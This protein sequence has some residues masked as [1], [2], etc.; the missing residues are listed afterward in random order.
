MG[1]LADVPEGTRVMLIGGEPTLNP[2]LLD[3]AQAL[4]AG[5]YLAGMQTNGLKLAKP[6]FGEAVR[7]AFDHVSVSIMQEAW[8][9][10][11]Q[12][13]MQRDVMDRFPADQ[14]D[15]VVN[16]GAEM[17][18]AL[19]TLR[20]LPG[21]KRTKIHAAS[22]NG[23]PHYFLSEMLRDLR[24]F[25]LKTGAVLRPIG[26]DFVCSRLGHWSIDGMEVILASWPPASNNDLDEAW[27]A[28]CKALHPETGE[29]TSIMDCAQVYAV[30]RDTRP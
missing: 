27:R 23:T 22:V 25:A 8:R 30:Q 7:E 12:A 20:F 1:T 6:A 2:E 11:A 18:A 14:W 10:R 19:Q 9:P 13:Q 21:Q 16:S 28:P 5:G 24:S 29:L 15:F 4:Q 3:Y 17:T 26:S